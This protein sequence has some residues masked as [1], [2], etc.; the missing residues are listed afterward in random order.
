[1]HRI[2][3][4]N[5]AG[6]SIHTQPTAADRRKQPGIT[7]GS[8][9][10][11]CE[12]KITPVYGK[13]TQELGMQH[14]PESEAYQI[15]RTKTLMLPLQC[16]HTEYFAF[17]SYPC[18]HNTCIIILSCCCCSIISIIFIIAGT[19]VFTALH[20]M[21]TQSSDE[22]SVCLSVCL[23]VCPSVTRVNR[24]KTVERSVQIFI[25]Y[26]RAFILVF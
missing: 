3:R 25:P 23:S 22:N 16:E 5:H 8:K 7:R 17:V 26:K 13:V 12:G 20:G 1:M 11:T 2:P 4:R 9:R 18:L 15:T 14:C 10:Q 6:A 24:D 21:Q 19:S